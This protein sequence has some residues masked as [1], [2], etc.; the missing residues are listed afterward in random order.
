MNLLDNEIKVLCALR[1]N[2]ELPISKLAKLL[3][4]KQSTVA[5][6]VS[7][8]LERQYISRFAIIDS[9]KLGFNEYDITCSLAI[10]GDAQRQ[11][12]FEYLEGLQNIT[13]VARI[14]GIFHCAFTVCA[15]S[16]LE[17]D[18]ILADIG[19]RFGP[20]LVDPY[21]TI[22]LRNHLFGA[23]YLGSIPKGLAQSVTVEMGKGV[24]A[25]DETDLKIVQD[26]ARFPE[27]SIRQ[28]AERLGLP[29]STIDYRI[30]ALR[31][32]KVL[33]GYCYQIHATKF[34]YTKFRAYIA[35]NTL[36]KKQRQEFFQFCAAHRNVTYLIEWLGYWNYCIGGSAVNDQ[37]ATAFINL[38]HDRFGSLLQKV[39]YFPE[40]MFSKV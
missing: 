23:K 5:H 28:A 36:S 30:K 40:F 35:V 8:L 24:F 17:V 32:A 26:L 14:G 16:P 25:A 7:K 1:L 6:A 12:F 11:S 39:V 22:A 33:L 3:G 18:N 21:I 9:S 10:R 2:S 4:M 19:D 37:E 31:K 27:S 29:H 13:S 15:K 20:V 34:G 38:I